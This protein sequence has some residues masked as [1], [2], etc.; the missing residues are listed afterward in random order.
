METQEEKLARLT[1]LDALDD[2]L[3]VRGIAPP[4]NATYIEYRKKIHQM[5]DWEIQTYEY[6]NNQNEL[7]K[8]GL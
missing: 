7:E 6:F 5:V 8:K 1:P 2:A 3:V 4:E